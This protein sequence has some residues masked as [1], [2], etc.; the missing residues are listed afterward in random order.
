M[1]RIAVIVVAESVM[2][3]MLCMPIVLLII[4]SSRVLPLNVK[5]IVSLMMLFSIIFLLVD[6]VGT[7]TLKSSFVGLFYMT[8]YIWFIS[9]SYLVVSKLIGTVKDRFSS[10]QG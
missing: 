2:F 1:L 5:N 9:L 6:V 4:R 8:E 10:R 3:A 7:Y